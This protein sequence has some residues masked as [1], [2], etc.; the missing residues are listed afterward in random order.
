MDK[1]SPSHQTT[2][3]PPTHPTNAATSAGTATTTTTVPVGR[4]VLPLEE[5]PNDQKRIR[6][7]ISSSPLIAVAA[8]FAAFSV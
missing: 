8:V 7:L 5:R 4:Y 1:L 6:K 3:Q 2:T